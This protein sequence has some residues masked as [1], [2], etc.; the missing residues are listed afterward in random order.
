MNLFK[1]IRNLFFKAPPEVAPVLPARFSD[2]R[3]VLVKWFV[4]KG[5]CPDCECSEV[6]YG[7][8]AGMSTNILCPGCFAEFNLALPFFAD[9]LAMPG[10]GRLEVYG[11]V[12]I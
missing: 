8:S 3:A 12:T 1:T 4:E 11:V 10:M 5:C 2:D 6:I 7:P 9:R